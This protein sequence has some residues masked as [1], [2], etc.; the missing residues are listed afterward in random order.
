MRVVTGALRALRRLSV[1][2]RNDHMRSVVA[3]MKKLLD[4]RFDVVVHAPVDRRKE[5][6]MNDPVLKIALELE[7]CLKKYFAQMGV[8]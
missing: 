5:I 7:Q 2:D 6:C 8:K 3:R 4:G 1:W